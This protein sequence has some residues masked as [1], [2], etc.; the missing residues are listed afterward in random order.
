MRYTRFSF[1][2]LE[3]I[4]TREAKRINS[5]TNIDLIVF[6]A[7]AGLP[8]ALYMSKIF[9][10]KVI[11]VYAERKMGIIKRLFFKCGGSFLPESVKIFLRWLEV[12]SGFHKRNSERHVTFDINITDA[13][14][15]TYK[16]ILVVDDSVDTGASLSQVVAKIKQAFPMSEIYTYG[17]NV[18]SESENVIKTDFFTLKDRLIKTPMSKDSEEHDAFL[19]MCRDYGLID[20]GEHE[21]GRQ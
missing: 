7:K 21:E 10:C 16:K 3:K 1:A 5:I 13:E 6:V 12:N 20:C 15:N 11:P 14:K 9:N 8:I 17:L 4:S 19:R 18:W 2:E